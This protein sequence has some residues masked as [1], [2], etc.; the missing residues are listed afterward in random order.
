MPSELV[1]R[2]DLDRIYPPFLE[3]VLQLLADAKAQG[4]T[5]VATQGWRSYAQQ[6]ALYAQGRSAPGP[7]VTNAQGG[8]SAHNFGIAIDLYA[9]S[10]RPADYEP[11]GKLAKAQAL[12]WG[13]DWKNKD[14]PHIQVRGFTS[15]AQL[16]PL[17]RTFALEKGGELAKLK[18][19]WQY[20]DRSGIFQRP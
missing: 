2:I 1:K 13:G 18:R 11:L 16:E 5:Y 17:H 4:H 14:L 3:R 15:A 19:V 20:L 9:G 6:D 10:W 8:R 12:E 7:A